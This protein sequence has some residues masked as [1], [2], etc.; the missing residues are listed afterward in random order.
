MDCFEQVE[1]RDCNE[2]EDDIER[3]LLIPA[4]VTL[5]PAT[6]TLKVYRAEDMPQ[7]RFHTCP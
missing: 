5:R 6:L 1:K 3:N 2:D 7:S 4:G